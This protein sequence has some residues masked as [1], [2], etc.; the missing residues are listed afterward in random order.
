MPVARVLVD[1][2]VLLRFFTGD[3]PDLARRA[4]ALI[5][6]ADAGEVVVV[7]HPIILSEVFYTLESF[8]KM[9]RVDIAE[10]LS[11]FVQ[12]QGIEMIEKGVTLDALDSCRAKKVHLSDAYL[13][14]CAADSKTP[15]ASFDRDFDKFPD[16]VRAE[17][18]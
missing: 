2:N 17:M 13:A 7:I 16:V 5:E 10:K 8:Y 14:A 1:S 12:H 11:L 4:R 9:S 15:V 18:K 6:R 3:P